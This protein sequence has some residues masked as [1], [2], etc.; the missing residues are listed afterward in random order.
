MKGLIAFVNRKSSMDDLEICILLV[1]V[2]LGIQ[3]P[4]QVLPKNTGIRMNS[5]GGRTVP[6]VNTEL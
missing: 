3:V 4:N 5:F 1:N 6:E 2:V